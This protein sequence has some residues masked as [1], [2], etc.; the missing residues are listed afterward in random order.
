M[1]KIRHTIV[2]IMIFTFFMSKNGYAQTTTEKTKINVVNPDKYGLQ[3]KLKSKE[4]KGEELTAILM[5]ASELVSKTRGCILYM[6]SVDK[7]DTNYIW[8]NEVWE[9]KEDHDNSLKNP[10]VRALISKAIP[11]LEGQPEKGIELIVIGGKGID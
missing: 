9:T 1:K 5:K 7:I 3:V 10:E 4:G 8:V 2:L 6:V 11:I